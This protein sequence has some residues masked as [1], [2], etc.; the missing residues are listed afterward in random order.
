[1][2]TDEILIEFVEPESAICVSGD[3]YSS[4]NGLKAAI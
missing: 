4:L 1:M 3:A 2:G